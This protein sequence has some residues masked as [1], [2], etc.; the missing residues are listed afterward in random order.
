MNNVH[1]LSTTPT[2]I[3]ASTIG[4]AVNLAAQDYTIPTNTS[5]NT[6]SFTRRGGEVGNAEAGTSGG[7]PCINYGVA[8]AMV[9]AA[10]FIGSGANELVPGGS[11]RFIYYDNN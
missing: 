2:I 11:I 5:F 7:D 8:G 9:K 4:F 1:T 3:L 6:I 10:F